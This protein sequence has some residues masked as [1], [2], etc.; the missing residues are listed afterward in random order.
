VYHVAITKSAYTDQFNTL[1]TG[2]LAAILFQESLPSQA[3][4]YNQQIS[5]MINTLMEQGDTVSEFHYRITGD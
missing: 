1:G 3:K 5:V 2:P 4:A